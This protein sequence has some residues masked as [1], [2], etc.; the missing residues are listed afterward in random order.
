MCQSK[1]FICFVKTQIRKELPSSPMKTRTTIFQRK[2]LGFH[3]IDKQQNWCTTVF[4]YE[5]LVKR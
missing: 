1:W 5:S 2:K 4:D 3:S